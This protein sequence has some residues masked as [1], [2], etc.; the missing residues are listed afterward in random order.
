MEDI[1]ANDI[2]IYDFATLTADESEESRNLMQL[3]P[4]AV[5]GASFPHEGS[6][7]GRKYPWGFVNVDDAKQSDLKNLEYVL[8]GA[9]LD[10]LRDYTHETLY[11]RYRAEKLLSQKQ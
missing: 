1:K 6:K 7:R 8:L 5:M 11:E 4:F 2:K 10:D 9:A 3:L